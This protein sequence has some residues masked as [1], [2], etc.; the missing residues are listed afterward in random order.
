MQH[1]EYMKLPNARIS[2]TTWKEDFVVELG[3][4]VEMVAGFS[5]LLCALGWG[6]ALCGI[7]LS[8]VIPASFFMQGDVLG[9]VLFVP[10]TAAAIYQIL[11]LARR[12]DANFFEKL[13]WP[14]VLALLPYLGV[15]FYRATQ[16]YPDDDGFS[17]APE[18]SSTFRRK[19]ASVTAPDQ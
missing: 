8:V 7:T 18:T 9:M 17:S 13:V 5:T 2:N 11:V 16:W 15:L 10:A 4:I 6:F 14:I 3:R 19:R 1:S 12:N